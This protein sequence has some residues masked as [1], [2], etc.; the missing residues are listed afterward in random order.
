MADKKF[1]GRAYDAKYALGK[2]TFEQKDID[3]LQENIVNGKVSVLLKESKQGKKYAEI[4]T[5]E[6]V[7]FNPDNMQNSSVAK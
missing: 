5:Y 3:L 4:D 1:I 6:Q 7:H 2:I